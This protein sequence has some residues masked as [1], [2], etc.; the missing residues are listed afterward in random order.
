M[1]NMIPQATLGIALLIFFIMLI[2]TIAGFLVY[3]KYTKQ[4]DQL[5]QSKAISVISSQL[6]ADQINQVS[7][8][9]DSFDEKKLTQLI[10]SLGK[11]QYRSVGF[12]LSKHL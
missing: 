3:K 9:F 1:K 8:L 2:I 10:E 11:R 7:K 5:M 12:Y 4:Y 6:T